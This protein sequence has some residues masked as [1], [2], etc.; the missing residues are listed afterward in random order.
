MLK[1]GL[2]CLFATL[3]ALSPSALAA[4]VASGSIGF[5]VYYGKQG[6]KVGEASHEWRLEGGSYR[7]RLALEANGLA[8][9]FGL[10]YEQHSEGSVDDH[11]LRPQLFSVDQRG[12]ELESARFDWAAGRVSVRRG[13]R[14]RR[15][16]E[17]RPGDQDLLSLW[18]Q[19]R[20]IVQAGVPQ[21]LT[22]VTNKSVK[23]VRLVPL[24][25]ETLSLPLGRVDTS[26]LQ[27]QAEEGGM[28]IDIWLAPAYQMLP[29]RIRIEDEKGSVLDQRAVRV[30][31]DGAA[32][33]KSPTR[34]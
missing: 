16:G 3:V 20:R 12:R 8:G 7:L 33:H 2:A 21:S 29:V 13:E 31:L 17:I 11:G 4:P 14:E 5:D 32:Q 18:H 30:S 23:K 27:A 24:G 25:T 19:A 1:R 34:N 15:S 9:L 10:H 22:V 28:K 6:F 26:R